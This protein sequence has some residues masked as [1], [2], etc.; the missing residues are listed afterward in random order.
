MTRGEDRVPMRPG[1]PAEPGESR[2]DALAR[3]LQFTVAEE[4]MAI[5]ADVVGRRLAV[6]ARHPR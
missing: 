5:G 1:R 6:D 3:M 4:D 2:L